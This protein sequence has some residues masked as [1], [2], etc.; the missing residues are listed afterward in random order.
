[1]LAVSYENNR[2]WTGN[3]IVG[4]V[5]QHAIRKVHETQ[6]RSKFNGTHQ[7]LVHADGVNLFGDNIVI[8]KEN[9]ETLIDASNG[10][11]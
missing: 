5:I 3:L 7:V 1:M 11:V 4:L 2:H 10:L 9:I 8:M 6:V